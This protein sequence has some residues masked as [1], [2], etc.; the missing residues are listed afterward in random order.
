MHERKQKRIIHILLRGK[1]S[2][3][4]EII[5]VVNRGN[6][7]QKKRENRLHCKAIPYGAHGYRHILKGEGE[8][9]SSD[10]MTRDLNIKEVTKSDLSYH[11][12][13]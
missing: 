4:L 10:N 12:F 8:L 11:E 3:A 6:Q 9:K 7:F 5:E 13:M 1:V 2:Q